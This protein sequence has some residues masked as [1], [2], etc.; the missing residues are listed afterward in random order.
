MK[1]A[2]FVSSVGDTDLA[3]KTIAALK[4]MDIDNFVVISLTETAQQRVDVF[5]DCPVSKLSIKELLATEQCPETLS[6]QDLDGIKAYLTRNKIDSVY[7]GVPSSQQAAPFQLAQSL[8]LPVFIAYEYMFKQEQHALWEHLPRLARKS[9]VRWSIP[10]PTAREDF[11]AVD[12]DHLHVTGH[13]SIDNA[14]N[15]GAATVNKERTRVLLQIGAE[16]SLTFISST[17][18]P[19]AVDASFVK[20]LLAEVKNHPH[21]QLRLGL[22]PGITDLDGYLNEILA[23][24]AEHPE[25]ASQ[26]KIILPDNLVAKL[27]HPELINTPLYQTLF[28]RPIENVSGAD[29]SAIAER[30]GQAVPGALLNQAALEGKAAYSHQGKPYL[31]RQF[32]SQSVSAFFTAKKEPMRNKED[33]QLDELTAPEKLATLML[34][35]VRESQQ[36]DFTLRLLSGLTVGAGLVFLL[37]IA[38]AQPLTTLGGLVVGL[39]A[40]SLYALRA[41][42]DEVGP[43]LSLG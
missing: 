17:T 23:V 15:A 22:H 27:K 30:V 39:A 8:D 11:T 43:Q 16:D 32:F 21:I 33:L 42:Q 41:G 5:Q 18:Q 34:A 24:F 25:A 38:L 1:I 35:Q 3:L 19:F 29:A 10:L 2:L 4:K 26:F 36:P 9:N 40:L 13:L 37:G 28:L 7:I 31:P 14:F 6:Q 12:E 20:A